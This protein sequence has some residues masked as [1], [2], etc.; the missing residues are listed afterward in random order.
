[1]KTKWVVTGV[2]SFVAIILLGSGAAPLI[3][4]EI[5]YGC[6]LQKKLSL[7]N[8]DEVTEH[9]ITQKFLD[10]YDKNSVSSSSSRSLEWGYGTVEYSFS[11]YGSYDDRGSSANLKVVIDQCG[12][13]QEFEFQCKDNSGQVWISA[14]SKNDDLSKYLQNQ[15]CFN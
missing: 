12:I 7:G 6:N 11:N 9:K 8:I 10:K 13:P 15:N 3:F 2:L 4:S 5:V 1:M 14:N